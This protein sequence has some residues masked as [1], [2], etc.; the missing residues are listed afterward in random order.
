MRAPQELRTYLS[1]L[2]RERPGELVRIREPVDPV[3]EATA[4]VMEAE[5]LPECPVVWLEQVGDSPFPTVVNVL[6]TKARLARGLGVAE[7][8]LHAA[9]GERVTRL[10]EPRTCAD[11]PFEDRTLQGADLDVSIIPA[12]THFEQDGGPYITGGHVVARD[13]A[14]GIET[15]GYHRIMV[16]GP[17][18][19]GISLHSRRRMFEYHRRAA[20]SGH[21][22][23]VAVV[24]GVPPAVSLGALAIPPAE[25]GKFAIIGGLL[26]APLEVARC[27]TVNL[28]VPRWAEIV[29]E[30]HILH[31][32]HEK[33]GPFGEFTGYASTRGT[34]N[35]LVPTAIQHRADAIYQSHNAGL[36]LEHCMF[37]AF[38]REVLVTQIL[39][40]II[41]NLKAVRVPIRSGCGSFHV[42]VSLRKTAEG[43]AKQAIMAVLG[44]DH[45]FKHVIVVDDDVDVFDDEEV[46]WAVATRVQADRDVIT[47][48]G[49]MG[50]LLDPSSPDG[51]CA[52]MGIDATRP[53]GPFASR[54]SLPAEAVARARL[55]LGQTQQPA[56][57][58]TR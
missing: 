11:A 43:Q 50:T 34:E 51:T 53:L 33:E 38:P 5:R 3:Y 39:R 18:R 23:E 58:A 4:I 8:D 48:S 27:R 22:L 12:L 29:I 36:S 56:T 28:S 46:L 7:G 13:P 25:A 44:A 14:T 47:A 32:E 17:Q 55:L 30:G 20:E 52:K 1:D 41:P 9:F 45:Y 6:Y 2:E 21:P 57:P 40:R 24:L 37:L 10:V 26:E 35:V 16:K 54:L 42:Y 49:G 31:D 19:L 15:I